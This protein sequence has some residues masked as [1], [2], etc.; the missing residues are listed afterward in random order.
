MRAAIDHTMSDGG[1]RRVF[2]SFKLIQRH[3]Q[4]VLVLGNWTRLIHNGTAVERTK[5]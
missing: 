1:G 5:P 3:V 2:P 4:R